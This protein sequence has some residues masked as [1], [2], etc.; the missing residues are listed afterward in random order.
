[1][2]K[3]SKNKTRF[4]KITAKGALLLL[5]TLTISIL[6][7]V[8]AVLAAEIKD[9]EFVLE[10]LQK[11][12]DSTLDFVADFR[13]ETEIK[14]LNRRLTAWGKVYFRRPGKMLWRYDEPKGQVLLADGEYLYFYQ[15]EEKQVIKSRLS[16]AIRSNTPLSFLLGMGDLKR[17]FKATLVNSEQKQY[18]V[19]L[20]PNEA[21]GGMANLLL[22][23]EIK[24]FDIHWVQIEDAVG[25]VTT[26]RFSDM[27][28]G[29][30]LKDSFFRLEVPDEVEIVEIGS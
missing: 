28:R 29:V 30:G 22:G 7:L 19:R 23:I 16:S 15:P 2:R 1:M 10:G 24:E 20:A 17:D 27:Q 4:E 18:V 8:L 21:I 14:A 9:A 3:K 11:R 13:Q 25:N 26:I 12:Y 6:S 5:V